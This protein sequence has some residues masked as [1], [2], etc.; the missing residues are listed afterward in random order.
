MAM[1]PAYDPPAG[2]NPG[3]TPQQ[4]TQKT[5]CLT[6]TCLRDVLQSLAIYVSSSSTAYFLTKIALVTVSISIKAA[7]K[8]ALAF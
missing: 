5:T 7:H 6:A 8:N 1:F 3:A 4:H 2:N